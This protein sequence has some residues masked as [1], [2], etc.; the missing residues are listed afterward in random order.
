MMTIKEL[1][2]VY[3]SKIPT[4]SDHPQSFPYR[5]ASCSDI[6]IHLPFIEFV[7]SMC[8]HC[9]EFGFRDGN[10]CCALVSGC[11]G[12]V[13]SYDV[14]VS[15]EVELFKKMDL[16][17]EWEFINRNTQEDFEIDPT[18]FLFID[19]QHTY[20]LTR[21]ELKK[22]NNVR[23]Y[24]GFHD[25]QSHGEISRQ[26]YGEVRGILP[27][28]REFLEANQQWKIVYDVKFNHGLLLLERK[29]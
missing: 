28:V 20:E 18:D 12:K 25:S 9:T 2:D 24:I 26:Q 16:Q 4:D 8:N 27:A 29:V 3:Y 1:R 10:S 14:V 6:S 7:A 21:N 22:H 17:C 15:P 5:C 13:V 11:K 23:K 19:T